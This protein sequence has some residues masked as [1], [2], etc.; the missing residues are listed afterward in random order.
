M[1][2]VI[3]CIAKLEHDYIEEFLKYHLKL[4]FKHVYLYDN[5]DVPTYATIL[6]AYKEELT[7]I[8]LPGNDYPKGVQYVALDHFIKEYLFTTDIT[9]VAHIDIDEF[10]A[11]K[12]HENIQNFISEYIV[13]DCGGIGMNW[14]I[15]G[16]SGKTEKTAEPVT[17]RFTMCEKNADHHIK[18]LFKKDYFLNYGTCHNVFLSNGFIK[19]T[20]N[21]VIKGPFNYDFDISVIQVNHYKCKT[22]P[23]F[24]YIRKRQ[25]AGVNN[26]L[27]TLEDVDAN[28][29]WCDRNEVEDLTAHDFYKKHFL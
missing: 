1:N 29:K 10:I 23:E 15:F 12:K 16:S 13:D 5:E 14:R 28:F 22:L 27:Q 20:N 24:R 7:V 19:C 3:V 26:A 25:R 4:G 9:H 2:P 17:Q 6:D 11:L 18:T 21:N 8:H